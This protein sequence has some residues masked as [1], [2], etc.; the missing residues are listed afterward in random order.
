MRSL[1]PQASS[2]RRWAATLVASI[3]ALLAGVAHAAS[4]AAP[5]AG[6]RGM[7]VSAQ[8]LASDVGADI[9]RRGRN[10]VDAAVAVGYALAVVYPQAGNIGGGGFMTLRLAD[11][12][13]RVASWKPVATG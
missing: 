2:L 11:G 13:T 12:P 7:V 6:S 8:H 1:V 9:L 5:V 4:P 3:G 10:P